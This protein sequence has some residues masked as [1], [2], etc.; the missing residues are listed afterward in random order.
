MYQIQMKSFFHSLILLPYKL[1]WDG[2][3]DQIN[4]SG[5]YQLHEAGGLK[6]VDVKFL[7]LSALNIGWLKRILC[8]NGKITK[9]LQKRCLSTQ[10]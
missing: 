2:K 6:M 4:R 10:I 8:D 7:L 3:H 5:A 1:V 9:I